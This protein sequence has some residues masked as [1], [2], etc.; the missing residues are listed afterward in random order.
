MICICFQY[1]EKANWQQNLKVTDVTCYTLPE[2]DPDVKSGFYGRKFRFTAATRIVE[3]SFLFQL[4]NY[5]YLCSAQSTNRY[6]SRIV[7]R[8]V[9]ILTLLRNVG[10]LTLRNTILE[11]LLRKVRIGTKWESH[12][13]SFI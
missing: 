1:G 7:L 3:N 6:D 12:F 13:I 9:G 8:K 2:K 10:I 4:S 11:L 5:A